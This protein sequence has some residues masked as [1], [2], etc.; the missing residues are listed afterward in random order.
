VYSSPINCFIIFTSSDIKISDFI[1]LPNCFG[2][3]FRIIFNNNGDTWFKENTTG[4]STLDTLTTT[5]LH[6]TLDVCV[7]THR[8][9]LQHSWAS[10]NL[11]LTLPT[12][13]LRQIPQVKGLVSQ[14]CPLTSLQ[15]PTASPGYHLCFRATGYKLEVPTTP[16]LGF[17]LLEWLTDLKKIP[18]LLGDCF[19]IEDCNSGT[20]RYTEQVMWEGAQ[21]F[22]T[23]GMPLLQY[24]HVFAS[25][26]GLWT[27]SLRV[28]MEASSCR[29][30]WINHQLNLQLLLLPQRSER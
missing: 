2:Y 9:I 16:S 22:H 8:A 30:D 13:R 7:S 12:W 10:Y 3:A 21:R 6:S 29:H 14:D 27:L 1:F 28:F 19:I 23:Q 17:N 26:E 24:L 18:Y 20:T 25:L 4:V 5:L 11:I 15:M